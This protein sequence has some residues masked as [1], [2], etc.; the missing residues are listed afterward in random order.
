VGSIAQLVNYFGQRG[1]AIWGGLLCA[2][3]Y[4]VL[5][6]GT[7]AWLA[8]LAVMTIGL[9]FYALHNTLQ[10]NATQMTPEARGT[11]VAVFSSAIYVGQS[12]GVSA[13]AVLFDR[14]GGTP[15][16]LIAAIALPTLALWFAHELRKRT[17]AQVPL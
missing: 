15:L 12:A 14:Y 8:P 17:A 11:A 13:A 1:L 16:F 5:A 9:G 10:T 7:G 6:A 3:A 2:A 4:L